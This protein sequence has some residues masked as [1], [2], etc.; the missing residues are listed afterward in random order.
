MDSSNRNVPDAV[1]VLQQAALALT[2]LPADQHPGVADVMAAVDQLV[3]TARERA[4]HNALMAVRRALRQGVTVSEVVT[5]LDYLTSG[6]V[7]ATLE[8]LADLADQA[9]RR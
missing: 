3:T 8:A 1:D 7:A 9:G 2:R 5:A 4:A 6:T